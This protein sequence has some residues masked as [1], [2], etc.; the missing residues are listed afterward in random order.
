[1]A[2]SSHGRLEAKEQTG[3][4]FW[5]DISGYLYLPLPVEEVPF[6]LL[7]GRHLCL[8]NLGEV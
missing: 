1:M 4:F 8:F 2:S 5:L 6:L 7:A 3:F